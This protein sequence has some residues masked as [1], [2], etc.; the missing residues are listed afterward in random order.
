MFSQIAETNGASQKSG[1]ALGRRG[2]YGEN[3]HMCGGKVYL[4]ERHIDGNTLYHR[5]CF[6]TSQ[7][8][9]PKPS[10]YITN[11][12]GRDVT[13]NGRGNETAGLFETQANK[14]YKQDSAAKVT[15][16]SLI[17]NISTQSPRGP[18]PV[19]NHPY[20]R[21]PTTENKVDKIAELFNEKESAFN[22][23]TSSSKNLLLLGYSSNAYKPTESSS[24]ISSSVSK[25]DYGAHPVLKA[26]TKASTGTVTTNTDDKREDRMMSRSKSPVSANAGTCVAL[27]GRPKTSPVEN[28]KDVLPTDS[29]TCDKNPDSNVVSGLLQSLT[30]IRNNDNKINLKTT[31]LNSQGTSNSAPSRTARSGAN[32]HINPNRR[33]LQIKSPDQNVPKAPTTVS[34][35]AS[36]T[37]HSS[38]TSDTGSVTLTKAKVYIPDKTIKTSPVSITT[39]LKHSTDSSVISSQEKKPDLLLHN[40]TTTKKPKSIL[41]IPKAEPRIQ[42]D[43]FEIDWTTPDPTLKEIGNSVP[44]PF[45]APPKKSE[46]QTRKITEFPVAPPR[47]FILKNKEGP[48]PSNESASTNGN[49]S[50]SMSPTTEINTF[51][52]KDSIEMSQKQPPTVGSKNAKNE[53]QKV[54]IEIRNK[55]EST[56]PEWMLEAEKRQ[57]MR[58]GKYIDPEK[59]WKT[60]ID[61]SNSKSTNV[62]SNVTSRGSPAKQPGPRIKETIN[63]RAPEKWVSPNNRKKSEL[64][65]QNNA[66]PDSET[67]PSQ[68]LVQSSQNGKKEGVAENKPEWMREAERRI[69]ERNGQYKDPEKKQRGDINDSYDGRAT[70][71]SI[72]PP[73]Y[74][75]SPGT[76]PKVSDSP[77]SAVVSPNSHSATAHSPDRFFNNVSPLSGE[78]NTAVSPRHKKRPAPPRP[79]VP[80]Y[81]VSPTNKPNISP[82]RRLVPASLQLNPQPLLNSPER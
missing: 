32:A 13:S 56:K 69:A 50:R 12:H 65:V 36:I 42:T 51:K 34:S 49:N 5:H 44:P 30:H 63:T 35:E 47:K 6:R 74:R 81:S 66:K 28:K 29:S 19:R 1:A 3:C 57:K 59:K 37:K 4:L 70:S 38:S 20:H 10:S 52:L 75:T 9:Q 48:K 8:T 23:T 25:T 72:S 76:S 60:D 33:Y 46:F 55:E 24:E 71:P 11:L 15:N 64:S 58:G 27:Q 80:P 62:I 39:K 22:K 78:D 14:G 54:E 79:S 43:D 16:K 77:R 21:Q 7:R 18:S 67:V 41:K 73:G 31:K 82:G 17:T 2:T 61:T 26:E 45:K 53:L 40:D 68:K